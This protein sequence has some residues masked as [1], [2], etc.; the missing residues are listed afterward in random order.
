RYGQDR[1]P[2]AGHRGHMTTTD[3]RRTADLP[4]QLLIG[5]QWRSGSAGTFTDRNPATGEPL[6]EVS[7]A[8]AEDVDAA[9]SA[10]RAQ[11]DGEW[12]ALPGTERARILHRIADLIERDT[13]LLARYES[14]DVGKPVGQPTMLD[15]P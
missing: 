9:V 4:D 6:V 5:G 12:G 8:S 11:L 15:I 1:P 14:L 7:A 3:S 2:R 10:A 13:D